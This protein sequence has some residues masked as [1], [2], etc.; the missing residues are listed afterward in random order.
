MLGKII[1]EETGLCQVGLGT[2]IQFYK[3]LGMVELDVEQSEIDGNYYLKSK[4]PH[5]T[6]EVKQQEK[7]DLINHLTCTALDLV[8]FVKNL[9][10][11][12]SIILKF[13]ND[14]PNIQLKLT[15]CKDVY[16]GVVRQLCP[17][18]ITEELVITEDMIVNF[19][20]QKHNIT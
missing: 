17:I 16:C 7:E 10:V 15:F 9:G 8:S 6:D 12:D 11:E 1:N 4:C 19:F 13:L 20:K 14:N 18:K 2:N 5:K 3:S